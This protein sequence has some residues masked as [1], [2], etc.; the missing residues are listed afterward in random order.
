[1]IKGNPNSLFTNE[2]SG[3]LQ[4]ELNKLKQG[5]S[6]V[7]DHKS[8]L[9]YTKTRK[10]V[11]AMN[12]VEKLLAMLMELPPK[13]ELAE[14]ELKTSEYTSEE[15]VLVACKFAESCFM[16]CR[17]FEDSFGRQPQKEEVHGA[18]L[19]EVCEILLKYGL[20]PNLIV[21]KSNIMYEIRYADYK[22]TAAETMRLLLENGGNVD[23]DDGDEPLF[24][25]LDFDIVFD[26]VELNNKV[27]FEQEFKLWLLM[28]GYGGT[29]VDNRCPV[30][31][32]DGFSTEQFKNFENFTYEIEF[33]EK[34]WIMHIFDIRTNKEVA[35]IL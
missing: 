24:R 18:Y 22:H 9:M 29:I 14:K 34:D 35:R 31:V 17:E 8:D 11:V 3:M 19:Y 10:E 6:T 5:N 33:T 2:E 27:F 1:M 23:I 12:K 26:V 21:D 16:E 25:S 32:M 28:I 7:V 20:N 13:F 15:V 4:E 30:D